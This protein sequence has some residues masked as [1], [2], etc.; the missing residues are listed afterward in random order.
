[1]EKALERIRKYLLCQLRGDYLI[2][3]EEG[4]HSLENLSGPRKDPQGEHLIRATYQ[5]IGHSS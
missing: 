3:W 1:M 5:L 2:H 4:C